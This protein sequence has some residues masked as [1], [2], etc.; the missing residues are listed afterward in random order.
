MSISNNTLRFQ[1]MLLDRC[2][3]DCEYF[4]ANGNRQ[5]QYLW[6]YDI[7]YHI[8]KMKEL[9]LSVPEK[10]EW[11]SWQEILWF[12]KAMAG[13]SNIVFVNWKMRYDMLDLGMFQKSEFKSLNR[14]HWFL[15]KDVQKTG[16][17]WIFIINGKARMKVSDDFIAKLNRRKVR[18]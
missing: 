2:R 10:P 5:E 4:L 16:V 1:Y 17:T 12:E 8:S 3:S 13:D 14:Y 9:W 18:C 15:I 11:L 7:A 6:G